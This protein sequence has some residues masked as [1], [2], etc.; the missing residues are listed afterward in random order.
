MRE[1]RIKRL[2]FLNLIAFIIMVTVN[3]LANI[4]PINDVTTGELSDAIENLFVPIGFTFAIWGLIY[5]MLGIFIIYQFVS[6]R[7]R[8]NTLFITDIGILFILNALANAAWIVSWHYRH[9]L[10]SLVLMVVILITL[11]LISLRQTTYRWIEPS[12]RFSVNLAFNVYLGWI[13][14][15]TIANITA[16][17]VVYKWGGFG[18][19][20][21][22]WTMIVI[23]VAIMLALVAVLLKREWAYALVIDWAILGIFLKRYMAEGFMYPGI[24]WICIIGM[25]CITISVIYTMFGKSR[26]DRQVGI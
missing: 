24:I 1:K 13:S 26:Y 15:A 9:V 2:A 4:L 23:A 12:E 19:S 20:A 22:I 14:V 11:I 25:I 10:I 17:L 6:I 21:Q 5:A 16:V 8:R 3:A 7:N 18:I